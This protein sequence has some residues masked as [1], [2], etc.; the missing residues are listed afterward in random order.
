[1]SD[2]TEKQ[3]THFFFWQTIL[4]IVH[5]SAAFGLAGYAEAENKDWTTQVRRPLTL[6]CVFI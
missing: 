3:Y 6:R 4:A 1:M 5:W 2:P